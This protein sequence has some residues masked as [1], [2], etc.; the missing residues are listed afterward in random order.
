M[1]S[2]L[3]AS[4]DADLSDRLRAL[5][6]VSQEIGALQQGGIPC[7]CCNARAEK[8]IELGSQQRELF[9]AIVLLLPS[10]SPPNP[11]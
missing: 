8:L 1:D 4:F 9:A 3:P 11:R 2:T 5:V 6:K 10:S 7:R